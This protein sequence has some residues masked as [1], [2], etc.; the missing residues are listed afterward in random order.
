MAPAGISHSPSVKS[1]GITGQ[2]TG[3]RAD[4]IIADDVE[5][6]NNS[7]TQ[8]MRDQLAER[9]KEF[10]AIIKPGG[11][12]TYLGTPQ[13]EMS[14]YNQL[15]DRGFDVRVWTCRIPKDTDRYKGTLAP[16]IIDLMEREAKPRD[17][18]DPQRFTDEDLLEREGSY[19]RSGF[20]LQ[21]ML[22]T[23]LSDAEKYPLKLED[24]MVMPLD[25]RMAPVKLVWS[26]GF[27]HVLND[28]PCVGMNADKFY[29]P[30][31]V[32]PDMAEYTGSVMFID[33]AGRGKDETAYA[34]VKMLN[35]FLFLVDIGGLHG[36]YNDVNLKTLATIASKHKVNDCIIESNFGD[37]M[38][39]ELL[40]PV[41]HKIHPCNIDEVRVYTQ[42]ERRIIDTLE[43]VMNQHRLII[44]KR[45][46]RQDHESASDPKYSLFYQMT[47]ITKE[48]GALTHD[49]RLDALAGAVAYWVEQMGRDTDKAA[50]D[51][52]ERLLNEELD[53]FM[54][55]ASGGTSGDAETWCHW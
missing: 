53:K 1:V 13:T 2:L 30:M 45:L 12:I 16:Y 52:R 26:S 41:M 35:G 25:T 49:D 55:Q 34:V 10:D 7:L 38:F 20:A 28:V 47:R 11:K 14:I 15:P 21:F 5:S 4:E 19:G 29:K 54:K 23:S 46:I 43:P 27:E 31:W 32:A 48:R 37:G 50:E 51:H 3:S 9:I 39:T 22:D 44:D 17:V 24:L 6:L 8:T 36:G 18:T 33:P 42:K 40:K